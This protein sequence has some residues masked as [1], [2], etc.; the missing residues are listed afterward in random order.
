MRFTTCLSAL[1]LAWVSSNCFAQTNSRD[2]KKESV[3]W[4]QLSATAP[5]ALD[6]FK[7]ATASL[8]S[9]DF[10]TAASLY[11]KVIDVAPEF[12][13][14]LRRLGM[15][16][17]ESGDVTHGLATLERA[18]QIK[19]SSENL[20]ALAQVL[21]FPGKDKTAP[22]EAQRRALTLIREAVQKSPEPDVAYFYQQAEIASAVGEDGDF[23]AATRQ[24]VENFPNVA[25][26]HYF[27][28]LVAAR[29]ERWTEAEDE[30]RR[31]GKLGLPPDVVKEFLDSGIHTRASV[32]RYVRYSAY[33]VIAW[34]TGL[35]LLFVL[36][37]GLSRSMLRSIEHDS[38][39]DNLRKIYRKLIGIAG[40]YYY[41][42][43][44]IVVLLLLAVVASTFYAF[45]TLGR[46]PIRLLVILAVVS[47]GTI[48][49]M[50]QSLLIKVKPADPGRILTREEAPGL[51]ALTEE[52]AKDIGTRPV[53]EIRIT[54]ATE[55]AVYERGSRAEKAND[56]AT[57]ILILGVGTLNGFRTSAFRAVLA[58]EYGHFSHRD[59]AG[60]DVALRVND[61]MLK[62]A[63]A[64]AQAGQ[65]VWWNLGFQ[66]VR[67]YHFLFRRISHGASRLQEVLAD[68]VAA[69]KY[70]ADAFEEGL[71]HVIRR[72]VEFPAV[73]GREIN[74]ALEG[75]RALQNLYDLQVES[76]PSFDEEVQGVLNRPTSED[77]THPSPHERFR[78]VRRIGMERKAD[79]SDQAMVWE[80]FGNRQAL[81]EEISG[82]IDKSLD[83]SARPV[84]E[85]DVPK[86]REIDL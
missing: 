85:S 49:K 70:G 33:L 8:D 48:Y 44:P 62:F 55:V 36:G 71:T 34:M 75:S 29:D 12:D 2:M 39:P 4:D 20:S 47:L 86:F 51:W 60:G 10:K 83:R 6:D 32:W 18:V 52:V 46:L 74:L 41:V 65:A 78:L 84:A 27:N 37:K 15:S 28:A 77:D 19:R 17:A 1:L 81:T 59:T 9:G 11:Q 31:A 72:S 54:P 68:R 56:R 57:R 66:F 14:A 3:I 42:S 40:V 63:Y 76:A 64:M 24:L 45:M 26:S 38:G 21:A 35:L 13:P 67:I 50:V 79:G 7:H 25:V 69:L 43:L 73:A 80:L 53:Q 82:A 61:D 30:I 16:L 22:P 58:H 23:R 5:A